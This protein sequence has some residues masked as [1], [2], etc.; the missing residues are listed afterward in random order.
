MSVVLPID[1]PATD[2]R[3]DA[4][5]EDALR[6]G[7]PRRRSRAMSRRDMLVVVG[8]LAATVGVAAAVGATTAHAEPVQQFSLQLRAERSGQLAFRLRIRSF[9]TTGAVPPGPTEAFV[10]FPAGADIHDAFR[11]PRWQCDGPALRLALDTRPSPTQFADRIKDLRP[12]IRSLAR[13]RSRSDRAALANA[14]AC[15]RSRIGSGTGLI[16]ARNVT[17]VLAD[18]IPVRY[19]AFLSRPRSRGAVAAAT[20]LGSADE[21]APIVRRYPVVAGVHVA[22]VQDIFDDPTP[23]GRYGLKM[24]LPTGPI[25]GFDVSLAEID[26]RVRGL[27]LARGSCVATSRRG[28]CTRRQPRDVYSFVLPACPPDGRLSAQMFSGFAPPLPSLTSTFE[29]PCPRFAR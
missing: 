20:V 29:L 12:F 11:G 6:R 19:T 4:G 2:D 23:D 15:E 10:R 16:D 28:R 8:V 17:P 13:G 25:A 14:R 27:K 3:T 1:L 7:R 22:V 5:T 26:V 21:G 9:D 24:L 18:P